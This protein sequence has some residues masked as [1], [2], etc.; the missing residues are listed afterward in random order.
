MAQGRKLVVNGNNH[1]REWL[2]AVPMEGQQRSLWK[3]G[4]ASLLPTCFHVLC[5][6]TSDHP[7]SR[8]ECDSTIDVIKRQ[9]RE[10]DG[11]FSPGP[12]KRNEL[13]SHS[14]NYLRMQATYFAIHALDALGE[15]PKH[16][17][18]FCDQLQDPS[19]LRGWLDGGPWQNPWL[20]SNNIMFALTFLQTD[21]EWLGDDASA[22]GVDAI[23]DYLDKRQDEETGLWQPDDETDIANSVYAAYHFF[24]YYFWRGRCPNHVNRIIDSTLSIQQPGGLFGGGACEDLDAVHILVMMSLVSDYRAADIRKALERCFWRLLQLQNPDG[25]FPNNPA[26]ATTNDF[27]KGWKRRLAERTGIVKILPKQ[28]RSRGLPELLQWYYSGW[29]PLGCLYGQSDLW[30]SWFRPLAIKLIAERYSDLVGEVSIGRYRSLP[31]L[32]WHDSERICAAA[33]SNASSAEESGCYRN[34]HVNSRTLST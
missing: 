13:S 6:E 5:S 22:R 34:S 1:L 20:H 10:A 12:L 30:G 25:G 29:K 16:R 15:R 28:L 3:N 19:Y 26:T 7:I 14:A 9:Q 23:L 8:D 11:L 18:S 27:G 33:T 31:G 21:S 24:P 17:V 2:A 32:G 4:H